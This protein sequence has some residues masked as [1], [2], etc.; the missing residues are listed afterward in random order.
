MLKL[1]YMSALC[2]HISSCQSTNRRDDKDSPRPDKTT[3][4]MFDDDEV[5]DQSPVN[6]NPKQEPDPEN[7]NS[8]DALPG[9]NS[10]DT[11]SEPSSSLVIS[12]DNPE[13][14][15]NLPF[16]TLEMT[17]GET[18]W[19]IARDQ[20]VLSWNPKTRNPNW[21]AWK[22]TIDD[23]GTIGRQDNFTIDPVLDTHITSTMDSVKPVTTKDYTGSCFDRGHVVASSD[24]QASDED[25][26]ATFY[27]TNV[28]PQTSFLNQRIWTGLESQTKKW[29]EQGTH[30]N[31][32]IVSGPVYEK[33]K[34]YIGP[35]Q[36]IAIPSASYKLIY[37]WDEF[38]KDKPLL[39]KAILVP[40]MLS[41]G[42][43]AY[44]AKDRLCIEATSG[45]QVKGEPILKSMKFDDYQATVQAIEAAAHI[46][47]PALNSP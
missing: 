1:L 21:V 24:R 4:P 18:S 16:G 28:V 2:L 13:G 15:P 5:P 27:M 12:S 45:G 44:E 6:K 10:G 9:D 22:M 14:N 20:Y 41:N 26:K 29:L 23:L 38:A 31:L 46:K 32:W 43:L 37:S 39:V 33:T 17:G 3:G 40:N 47:L 34:H 7:D 35:E 19:V 25:N 30:K 36:N 8:D 42:K 11:P